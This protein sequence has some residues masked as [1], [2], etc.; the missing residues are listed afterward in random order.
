M[1]VQLTWGQIKRRT[2]GRHDGRAR[3]NTKGMSLRPGSHVEEL[4][5]RTAA[6]FGDA[7]G[8]RYAGLV[9]PGPAASAGSTPS[10]S[11]GY[12]FTHPSSRETSCDPVPLAIDR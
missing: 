1:G 3:R 6:F 2:H 5:C 9:L 4:S 12:L 11:A 7:L 8:N 10:S